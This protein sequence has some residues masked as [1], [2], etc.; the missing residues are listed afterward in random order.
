MENAKKPKRSITK[1]LRLPI[2]LIISSAVAASAYAFFRYYDYYFAISELAQAESAYKASGLHWTAD[3][4][5]SSPV[6]A[7][8]EN[9]AHEI[10]AAIA[11][12]PPKEF[13]GSN[14]THNNIQ[15]YRATKQ[16]RLLLTLLDTDSKAFSLIA[17]A[18]KK[19]SLDFERDWDLG[20]D[21]MFF[22]LSQMRWFVKRLSAR[23]EAHAGLG[24]SDKAIRYIDTAWK[25]SNQI[26]QEP[27]ISSILACQASRTT[28]LDASLRCISLLPQSTENLDALTRIL[29]TSE[30]P[31]FRRAIKGNLY[32][33]LAAMR[34]MSEADFW[35]FIQRHEV[36]FLANLDVHIDGQFSF[37]TKRKAWMSRVLATSAQFK[38]VLDDANLSDAQIGV[39]LDE[40]TISLWERKGTA[41]RI[42]MIF[43]GLQGVG[44]A[45]MA[46][47]ARQRSALA[48]FEALRVKARTSNLPFSIEENPDIGTDPFTG[49]LLKVTRRNNGLRIYSV[50]PDLKDEGG[51]T[52]AESK[53]SNDDIV[54]IYPPLPLKP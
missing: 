10:R 50:G 32:A 9:A 24:Q 6:V 11:L 53:S 13:E 16:H 29:S 46:G 15:R 26:G 45:N 43:I 39:K 28:V 4:L 20:N 23:A 38:N 27:T 1:A 12:V 8:T 35:P 54:M 14:P 3:D 48:V 33:D 21:L 19:P 22:E 7:K 36:G 49:D 47:L 40:I 5:R 31:D 51:L 44:E 34:R 18:V 30:L 42:A 52:K 17:K 41:S 2:A 25:L 37:E